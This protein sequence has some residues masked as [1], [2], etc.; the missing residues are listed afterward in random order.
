MLG[1]RKTST[2]TA[3][4]E[5]FYPS[6]VASIPLRRLLC[7]YLRFHAISAAYFLCSI[8]AVQLFDSLG[9]LSL[10][11]HAFVCGPLADYCAP[12]LH[13]HLYLPQYML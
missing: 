12:R 8:R 7:D 10:A 6:A 13:I 11:S 3:I 4:E 9:F 5:Q 1:A 2:D